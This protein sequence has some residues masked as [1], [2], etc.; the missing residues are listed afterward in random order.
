M[1]LTTCIVCGEPGPGPRCEQHQLPSAPKRFA[2]R[3]IG[4]DSTWDRLSKRARRMQPWCTDC[5]TTDDLTA[6]HSPEAWKR[7]AEGK[8]I[9]LSDVTVVCRPCNAKRGRARP[10]GMGAHGTPPEPPRQAESRLHTPG[11]YA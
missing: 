8:P 11:G 9:R 7:K 1:T 10:T 2:P 3:K 6:D 5:G 4:Y